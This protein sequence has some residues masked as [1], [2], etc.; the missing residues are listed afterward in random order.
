[1]ETSGETE[2]ENKRDKRTACTDYFQKLSIF[3]ETHR[4]QHECVVREIFLI[5]VHA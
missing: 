5:L 2:T 4:D 1:M 3:A